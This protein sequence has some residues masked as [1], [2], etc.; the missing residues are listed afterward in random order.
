[1]LGQSDSDRAERRLWIVDLNDV[2]VLDQ[3]GKPLAVTRTVG[4]QDG[5]LIVHVVAAKP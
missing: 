4:V 1:V 3:D 5:P 2:K